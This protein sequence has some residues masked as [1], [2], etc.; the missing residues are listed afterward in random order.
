MDK[1]SSGG[2]YNV[3]V[4]KELFGPYAYQLVDK[5][6]QRDSYHAIDR[7]G[8]KTPYTESTW[9]KDIK[10]RWS[11]NSEGLKSYT[12]NPWI[13]NDIDGTN[14]RK[15]EEYPLVYK[16]ASY[17]AGVW[18]DP[19]FDCGGYINDWILSYRI[20][21]FGNTGYGSAVKFRGIVVVDVKLDLLDIEQC[22]SDFYASNAFMG[23]A[24]CDYESTYCVPIE[25]QGFQLHQGYRCN[26]KQ[27]YE[28]PWK[29]ANEYF[30]TGDL[31]EESR[32]RYLDNRTNRFDRLK[33][34][35][36]SATQTSS[37]LLTVSLSIFFAFLMK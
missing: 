31:I 16:S 5:D 2:S 27:G 21:F 17:E 25:N 29:G 32:L 37:M 7:A 24:R 1:V 22:P 28:Y 14:I 36:S 12:L 33:C 35:M 10:R 9:Y 19:Y 3:K 18:S 11:Y 30:Y 23:T 13:R 26:C 20:P 8:E 15:H 6:S 4:S 34:R